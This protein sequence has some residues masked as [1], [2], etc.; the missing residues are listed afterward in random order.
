[1]SPALSPFARGCGV[2]AFWGALRASRRDAKPFSRISTPVSETAPDTFSHFDLTTLKP[3]DTYKLLASLVLPRPIAWITSLDA[4]GT[5]NVAPFSFFNVLSSDPPVLAVGFSAAPDREGKD[6]FANITAR[7]QFVV[8]MVPEELADAMN[9]TATNVPRG[10]SETEFA[11]LDLAPTG[12]DIPRLA[13]SPASFECRLM[14][15]IFP[16]PKTAIV[17]AEVL[18]AHVRTEAFS[19]LERLHLDSAKLRLV[20]RMESPNAY[21]TTRDLFRID[22]KN[23][24]L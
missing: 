16:G 1:V 8:N 10:T 13:G 2:S 20:G 4:A 5:L 12:I 3:S 15:T 21:V 23:W 17:L 24:P 6:T 14:Q 11:D 18:A 9:L 7:R 22:R 19:D